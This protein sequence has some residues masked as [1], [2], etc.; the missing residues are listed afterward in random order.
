MTDG[1]TK[2]NPRERSVFRT[3]MVPLLLLVVVEV[4]ILMGSLLLSGM[5]SQLDQNAQ[6]IVDKQ[7]ENRKSYLENFMVDDWSDLSALA[8]RV[9]KVTQTMLDGGEIAMEE[10]DSSSDACTP[11]LLNVADDLISTLYAKRVSGIYVIFNTH[12]L[13]DDSVVYPDKT[14]IY[15]R[16]L[17]PN[18]QPSV[19][20][21]DLLLER[22]PIAVVQALHIPSDAGW[23]PKFRFDK[24]QGSGY[25]D[26]LYQPY[27]AAVHAPSLDD[28][29]DYGY[30]SK[31]PFT[32]QGS[33]QSAISYSI[34]L[35]LEDGTV[36][37]VLGV[38]LLTDYLRTYLPFGELSGE[39]QGSY[40]L[41]VTDDEKISYDV[42]LI[43]GPVQQYLSVGDTI[44]LEWN[45]DK[46][47]CV[48]L[49]GRRYYASTQSLVLYN[50]NTP[51]EG[52]RWTLL[53]LVPERQ[54]YAFSQQV[55]GYLYVAII[56]TL[57][58]GI[59]GSVIISR[60]ISSPIQDLSNELARASGLKGEIPQLSATGVAELDHFS[61]VFTAL[62]REVLDSSTKFLRIMEMASVDIGGFEVRRSDLQL[63]VT[64]N[65]FPLFGCPDIDGASLT[66]AGF[67]QKMEQLYRTLEHNK[68]D[69]NNIL[70]RIHLPQEEM[71]YV[72]FELAQDEERFVG[73][74]EDVTQ[75]TKERLR[76][77]HERDY[78]LLT[79]LNSRRAF[80]RK[81]SELFQSP[82]RLGRYAALVMM[83]LDN[84][85]LTNDRF[86]HDW[87]DQYI[88]QAGQCFSAAAPAGALCARISGDEFCIF[89]YGYQEPERLRRALEFLTTAISNSSFDLPNGEH[90]HISA[91]GGVAWYPEDAT[92]FDELMKYADFAM[93]QVK[94]SKKGRLGEFD[95]AVYEQEHLSIQSRREFLRLMD[96]E[97]LAYHFQPIVDAKTGRP[98]AYEALMRPNLPALNSPDAVLALARKENRL[99]DVERLTWFKSAGAYHSLRERGLVSPEALLFVNSI[100][101]QRL[102]KEDFK[103]MV[104]R[105]GDL[106]PIIVIEI[107]EGDEMDLQ[108]LQEKRNAPGFSG[109]LALDDYGSGYNSEKNLL[110]LSPKFI[111]IDMSIIRNVNADADKR[112]LVANITNYAHERD[113]QVVAEGLET[114][115]ELRTVLE[116]GVDLLQ[117]YLLARP[118][119]E[120]PPIDAHAVETIQQFWLDHT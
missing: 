53:G 41:A 71:R 95:R 87:G 5:V 67:K 119:L 4:T 79:G 117:G 2:K 99:Y 60:R 3:I 65:F 82:E 57:M 100:A 110:L 101:S 16:D 15:I 21:T 64:E 75:A 27:V 12:H 32:L 111:K 74:V 90:T 63:F 104:A 109:M 50:S 7:M 85:K 48:T 93:Y 29:T 61:G 9:N 83:D 59:I 36:Y 115:E 20:N 80:Y 62:S 94:H 81:A 106:Q 35:V 107:T 86:G 49:D 52:D 46:G 118:G 114:L 28:P 38:D 40:L 54:L 97:Q 30:W 73:L 69:E 43:C 92:K 96:S 70:F 58:A 26:F 8:R 24:A 72:R 13:E 51:F 31:R 55:R 84:L 116:L 22:A 17:D 108:A 56:C 78:D 11:L 76:I 42:S 77:E 44:D 88:R 66:T 45:E 113:M 33:T 102:S 34:P 98:A 112:Q 14:G 19:L 103:T 91:S 1:T 37:G 6:E 47:A 10:L 25:Y 68:V 120:P 39:K 89:F 18:S 105:Y 23:T